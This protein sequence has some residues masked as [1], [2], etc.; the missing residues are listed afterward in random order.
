MTSTTTICLTILHS[1]RSSTLD[2]WFTRQFHHPSRY[3]AAFTSAYG[4]W[5]IST[6]FATYTRRAMM[7][8]VTCQEPFG[9]SACFHWSSNSS[10]CSACSTSQCQ[11]YH[12]RFS[13]F[14]LQSLRSSSTS[15]T[16]YWILT[17]LWNCTGIWGQT[18]SWTRKKN[19]S[20]TMREASWLRKK[21]SSMRNKRKRRRRVN[22]E[23]PIFRQNYARPW[24]TP[25]W[26]KS[27]RPLVLIYW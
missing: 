17:G 21:K 12:C 14:R 20:G 13:Y 22:G 23:K 26:T 5:S 9:I 8:K 25:F 15:P 2:A 24:I 4:L 3:L 16:R 1:I 10:S 11:P 27:E 6:T 7:P 19:W 18:S